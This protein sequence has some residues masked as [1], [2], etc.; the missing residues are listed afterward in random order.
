MRSLWLASLI[1]ASLSLS[2]QAGVV[3]FT[4]GDRLTG[5]VQELSGGTLKIKTELAGDLSVPL[6]KVRTF[7][8]DAPVVLQFADDSTL[9]EKLGS[10]DA[11]R[12]I[13]IAREGGAPR[14]LAF[15]EIKAINPPG[16][17][18]PKWE[19]AVSVGGTITSGNTNTTLGKVDAA[20]SRRAEKD[21]ITM[22][23]GF[24]YGEEEDP[25]TGDDEVTSE[26]WLVGGKYDRFIT[27]K[28]YA[29]GEG[30][31]E[32]DVIAKLSRR[33]TLGAGG[34]Y[35]WVESNGTRFNTEA[36]LAYINEVYVGGGSNDT[37]AVRLAYN[38]EK[39]LNAT[40]KFL[41]GT[42]WY[43]SIQDPSDYLLSTAAELRTALTCAIFATAKVA[44][45]YDSTPAPGAEKL[46]TIYTMGLGITLF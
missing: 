21:R 31:Y 13:V 23:A 34:G 41:H 43:P 3:I 29:Y 22:K 15:S 27:K 46:D 9:Q 11:E 12:G 36:G 6:D 33:M 40:V 42:A 38:F 37:V 39:E 45:N 1:A 18:Q 44:A 28:A 16:S 10:A 5:E 25:S 8:T 32:R 35:Q 24:L 30:R 19:G 26:N 4:N 20:I 14:A 2:A 17:P 7:S